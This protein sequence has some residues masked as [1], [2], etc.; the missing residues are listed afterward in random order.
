MGQ[1]IP[2]DETTWKLE[3][4]YAYYLEDATNEY[5]HYSLDVSNGSLALYAANLRLKRVRIA[6][7]TPFSF[8]E[9]GL[10]VAGFISVVKSLNG[11]YC[12]ELR[13]SCHGTVDG[14]PTEI[15]TFV[16]IWN[17]QWETEIFSELAFDDDDGLLGEDILY[18]MLKLDVNPDGSLEAVRFTYHWEQIRY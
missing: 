12:Y 6:E 15:D 18:G 9:D 10:D 5:N 14:Q 3:S 1:G 16:N 2:F 17:L 8:S 11:D 4:G 13:I 7:E